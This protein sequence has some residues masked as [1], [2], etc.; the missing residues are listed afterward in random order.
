M[1]TRQPTFH[2][3]LRLFK[4]TEVQQ[5][6]SVQRGEEGLGIDLMVVNDTDAVAV[7]CKSKARHH[8]G[9]VPLGREGRE[10]PDGAAFLWRKNKVA[11]AALAAYQTA[12]NRSQKAVQMFKLD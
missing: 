3:I 12:F 8:A 10:L 7:E 5:N 4:Q 11:D 9:P 1:S 6:V 2:D